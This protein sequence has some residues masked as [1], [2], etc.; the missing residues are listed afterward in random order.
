MLHPPKTALLITLAVAMAFTAHAIEPVILKLHASNTLPQTNPAFGAATAVSDKWLI[1]GEPGNDDKASNAGAVHVFDRATGKWLRKLTA[2]DFVADGTFG[3]ALGLSG[4]LA[5][6]TSA[7]AAYVF[8]VSTGKQLRKLV[9]SDATNDDGYVSVAVSGNLALVGVYHDAANPTNNGAVYV[10]D[11]TTGQQL[12]KIT[13]GLQDDGFGLYLAISGRIG[14]ITASNDNNR[15]GTAYLY[16]LGSGAKIAQL[17]D[18]ATKA[19][20]FFGTACALS[21]NRA[22]VSNYNGESVIAFD[23]KTGAELWRIAGNPGT[24][25]F[26][27]SLAV[28]GSMLYVGAPFM[29]GSSGLIFGYNLATHTRVN[30]FAAPDHSPGVKFGTQLSASGNT[31]VAGMQQDPPLTFVG[32]AYVFQNIAGALPTA[33]IAKVND[34]APEAAN[35]SF[36]KFSDAVISDDNEVAIAGSVAGTGAPAGK[37]LGQWSTLKSGNGLH[38]LL[39]GGDPFGAGVTATP[40]GHPILNNGTFGIL[41]ATLKGAG[42]SAVNDSVLLQDDGTTLTPLLREGTAI[43]GG[44]GLLAS[45]SKIVQSRTTT[46]ANQATGA[47][48][49]LVKGKNAITATNDSG[50][51]VL[52]STAVPA[53][54]INIAEDTNEPISAAKFG[55]FTG[56]LATGEQNLAWTA[57]LQSSAATNQAVFGLAIGSLALKPVAR[58]DA[59]APQTIGA[60]FSSFI[61]ETCHPG[62]TD[63]QYLIR[64]TL[65]GGDTTVANNEG[66]WSTRQVNANNNA[67]TLVLRKGDHVP[68][69]AASI[70]FSAITRYWGMFGDQVLVQATIKG[71][72]ITTANDTGLWLAQADG[73]WLT[74]LREGDYAIGCND[75]A[76]TGTLQQVEVDTLGGNYAVLVSLVGGTA[77]KDQLLLTGNGFAGHESL[78]LPVARLRKGVLHQGP[79]SIT[80]ILSMTMQASSVEASGAGGTGAGNAI[81]WLGK[82][83]MNLACA[84]KSVQV[85]TLDP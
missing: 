9:L 16:D 37:V 78:R 44:T 46:P 77:G 27:Q 42:I 71:P 18:P 25:G 70:T 5:L 63:D 24:S 39:R 31:I 53:L 28:A 61:G 75:G 67:L 64:A 33:T 62:L 85:V 3:G 13:S 20:G 50:I 59:P 35:A 15:R 73:T 80:S 4:N 51:V 43:P 58:K 55:Q 83:V 56:R 11:I 7:S 10:F 14:L 19:F 81:N 30:T 29:N 82:L 49:A 69:L 34:F 8:D 84:D 65:S 48:Y 41:Q 26:G 17:D 38:L 40:F 66:L 47:S 22:F 68:G 21:D 32:A 1:A 2:V 54:A 74:L 36:A 52:T 72:G 6:I 23:V 57:A 60:K 12:R 45:W 79:A 76:K